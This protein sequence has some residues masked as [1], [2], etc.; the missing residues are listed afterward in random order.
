MPAVVERNLP[1]VTSRNLPFLNPYEPP[2][3]AWV[4]NLDSV[5]E[6]KLGL[7]DLHPDIFGVMPRLD[8]IHENIKWQTH[9][10]RVV[11]IKLFS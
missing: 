5:K 3:Q 11:R 10:K 7:V 2:R 8:V 1:I 4:E 6:Q 9:Y